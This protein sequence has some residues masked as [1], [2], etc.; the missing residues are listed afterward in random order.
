ME[1][2]INRFESYKKIQKE[3]KYSELKGRKLE[4]EKI[5]N[6]FASVGGIKMLEN[7]Q[8]KKVRRYN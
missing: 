8:K 6:M 3:L 5:N 7:L 4:K 2:H 1:L